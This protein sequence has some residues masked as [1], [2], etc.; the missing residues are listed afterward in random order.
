M[1]VVGV[2][3]YEELTH[4]HPI[5]ELKCHFRDERTGAVQ[6]HNHPIV[7]LKYYAPGNYNV[8][9]FSHNHPIVE[10]K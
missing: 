3:T 7:E 5:V 10:L 6:P 2:E 4:N 9:L 8:H 1:Q